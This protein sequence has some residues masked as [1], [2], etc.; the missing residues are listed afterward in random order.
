M[1]N[2]NQREQV[3]KLVIEYTAKLSFELA[4]L[5]KDK[6][7]GRLA[8]INESGLVKELEGVLSRYSPEVIAAFIP[9]MKMIIDGYTKKNP[10]VNVDPEVINYPRRYAGHCKAEKRLDEGFVIVERGEVSKPKR[11][12]KPRSL[13]PLPSEEVLLYLLE[14]QQY[15]FR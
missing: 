1:Q 6:Y 14:G 11:P 10:E 9:R 7:K 8:H 12:Q 5:G 15:H 13:I 4:A 2:P 3:V